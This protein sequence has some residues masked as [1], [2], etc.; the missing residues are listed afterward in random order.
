ERNLAGV[1]GFAILAIALGMRASR[2]T[3]LVIVVSAL[4][5]LL[6]LFLFS[7]LHIIHSYY[8]TGNMVFLIYA[9]SVALGHVLYLRRKL[10]AVVLAVAMIG[11]NYFWFAMEQLPV[12]RTDFNAMNSRDYAVGEFLRAHVPEGS[13]FVAF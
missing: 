9:V 8:Q 10:V 4:L 7:N 2:Q 6:P 11:S 1:L 3:K 5:G 12:V 13:Y